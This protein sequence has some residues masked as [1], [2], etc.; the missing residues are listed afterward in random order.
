MRFTGRIVFCNQDSAKVTKDSSQYAAVL[1]YGTAATK[2]KNPV[3]DHDDWEMWD[4]E[5]DIQPIK[6]YK[7]G[8]EGHSLTTVLA[9]F[10][11]D[12][13]AESKGVDDYEKSTMKIVDIDKQCGSGNFS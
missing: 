4:C 8:H 3:I 5:I 1:I 7:G 6:K 10:G 13:W 11:P 9:N 12:T 2:E